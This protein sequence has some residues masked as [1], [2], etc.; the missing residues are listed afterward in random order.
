MKSKISGGQRAFLR[1]RFMPRAIAARWR[2]L[3]QGETIKRGLLSLFVLC[4]VLQG[5]MHAAEDK[6]KKRRPLE[7][8]VGVAGRPFKYNGGMP[9]DQA[10]RGAS[11]LV[12]EKIFPPGLSVRGPRPMIQ[13]N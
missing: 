11:Y 3:V 1:I 12:K 9:G 8:D 2:D 4:F 6:E 7:R 13:T 10:L 5:S